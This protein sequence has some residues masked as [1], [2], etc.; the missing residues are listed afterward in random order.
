VRSRVFGLDLSDAATERCVV[1][2]RLG[3]LTIDPQRQLLVA[4][5]EIELRHGLIDERLPAR[6]GERLL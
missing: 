3:E 6:D 4:L 1:R 5:L 2:T